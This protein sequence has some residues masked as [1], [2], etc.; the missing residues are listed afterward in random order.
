MGTQL[1]TGCGED[2]GLCDL[3]SKSLGGVVD[4]TQSLGIGTRGRA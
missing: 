2:S 1:E 3:L 4:P